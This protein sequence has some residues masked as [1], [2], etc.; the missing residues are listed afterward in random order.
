MS[1]SSPW[2]GHYE[3]NILVRLT[4]S[5]PFDRLRAGRFDRLRAGDKAN[6][7]PRMPPLTGLEIILKAVCYNDFAPLA[8]GE[9]RKG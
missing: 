8:L 5:W 1:L 9:A 2:P 6:D 4:A 7:V 3:F